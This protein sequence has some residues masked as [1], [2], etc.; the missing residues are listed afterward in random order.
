VVPTL[1]GRIQTRLFLLAVVGVPWTLIISVVAP[2][3][4]GATVGGLYETTFWV[5][6]EVAIVGSVFWEPLY[7]LSMQFRWEKDWPIMFS[8]LEGIPEGIVAYVLLRTFGPSVHPPAASTAT[9]LTD[10]ITLWVLVWLTAIG[11]MRV[12]VPR[13]RFRG[14]RIL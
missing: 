9:F 6:A 12:L 7:H 2:H 4:P 11:P 5:L 13:W 3:D 8:L 14:G 10:F 1:G